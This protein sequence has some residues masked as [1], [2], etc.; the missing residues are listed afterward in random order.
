MSSLALELPITG[1]FAVILSINSFYGFP[2][3]LKI[4]K[5]LKNIAKNAIYYGL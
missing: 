4:V 5:F 2:E 3:E 1:N